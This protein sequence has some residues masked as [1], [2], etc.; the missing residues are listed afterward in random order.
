MTQQHTDMFVQFLVYRKQMAQLPHQV[1]FLWCKCA[2]VVRVYR[3]EAAGFHLV[4]LT[5]NGARLSLIV[6]VVEQQSVVHVPFRVLAYYGRLN[7]EL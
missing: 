3:R 7:L 6:D 2:R 1:N 5:V 4:N